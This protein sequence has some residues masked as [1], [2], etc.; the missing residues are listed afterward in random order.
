MKDRGSEKET[1]T[2]E[3]KARDLQQKTHWPYT[4]VTALMERYMISATVR[5][6]AQILAYGPE[7]CRPQIN[8]VAIKLH[9]CRPRPQLICKQGAMCRLSCHRTHKAESNKSLAWPQNGCVS[10][11]KGFHSTEH[12]G[13]RA[14][15]CM[16]GHKMAV[17]PALRLPYST[18]EGPT[19]QRAAS[20]LPVRESGCESCA[21]MLMLSMRCWKQCCQTCCSRF[22]MWGRASAIFSAPSH[23]G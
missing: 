5:G 11:S 3:T 10:R 22:V 9:P 14:A 17:C 12:T 20:R 19:G 15:S 7:Y 21:N 16:P 13:Q 1:A 4:I 8:R 6:A 23:V 2:S 18:D